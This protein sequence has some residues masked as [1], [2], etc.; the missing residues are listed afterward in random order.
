MAKGRKRRSLILW[1]SIPFAALITLLALMALRLMLL[2]DTAHSEKQQAI[3]GA[4]AG[5]YSHP[6][7]GEA[8]LMRLSQALQFQ[9]IS[10]ENPADRDASAFAAFH[11]FLADHFPLV[12]ARAE[13]IDLG[14]DALFFKLAGSKPTLPGSVLMAHQDVVPIEPGTDQDWQHPPFSGAIADGHIWG[15]GAMD[16]KGALLAILEA[17]EL[18]LADGFEPERTLWL[19]FGADEEVGGENGAVKIATWL[20]EHDIPIAFA[21]DEGLAVLHG[22]TPGVS[23]PVAMVGLAEKGSMTIRLSAQ[24]D[25]GHSS[26]PP[27][28]SA[29]GR[30]AKALT[31]LERNPMPASLDGIPAQMLVRLAPHMDFPLD[32]ITANLWLTEALV[33]DQFS[34]APSSNSMIRTT[35]AITMLQAGFKSNVLAQTAEATIN[36]RLR[37]GDSGQDILDHVRR[38]IDDEAITIHGTDEEAQPASP[39]SS[40]QSAA[41]SVLERSIAK[42]FPDA[43]LAPGLV[44]AATDGRHFTKAADDVYRFSP[45]RLHPDDLAR[46]HGTNE[47]LKIDNYLEMIGFYAELINA[48]DQN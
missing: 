14:S 1:L 12:H 40:T 24:E 37:P 26:M 39:I 47:R 21:L 41:F 2:P 9:T 13:R 16:D 38:V 36:F 25:G 46:L 18:L 3:T 48:T 29:P 4:M 30:L 42:S 5:A 10:T 7:D 44:I 23:A 20:S 35:T 32:L 33:I 34:A 11:A 15:R 43:L 22:I 17:L 6:I 31:R 19:A 8:A 45:M 27:R 28:I